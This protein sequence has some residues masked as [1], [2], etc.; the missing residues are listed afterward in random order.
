MSQ[1][2][3]EKTVIHKLKINQLRI[4]ILLTFSHKNYSKILDSVQTTS[5]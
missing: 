2:K 5:C 1:G 3:S 4:K